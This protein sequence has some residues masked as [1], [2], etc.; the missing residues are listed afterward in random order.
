MRPLQALKQTLQHSSSTDHIASPQGIALSAQ[1]G[2]SR[3]ASRHDA[4]VLRPG[5]IVPADP[6]TVW[7][8]QREA[9]REQ[10]EHRLNPHAAWEN[11][12]S[13]SFCVVGRR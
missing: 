8:R 9:D 6:Y 2:P 4:Q 12:R 5:R 11:L 10:E 1:D 13:Q 7:L 3:T